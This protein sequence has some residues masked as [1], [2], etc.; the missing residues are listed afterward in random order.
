MQ[1]LPVTPSLKNP[2]STAAFWAVA[3]V[4]LFWGLGDTGLWN[5]E[6]RWVEIAREMKLSGNYF[7]P[8][9]NGAL[10]FDKPLLS[11]WLVLAFSTLTG[12][13][14]EWS[15]RLP[16]AIG[17]LL[18][19][20]ATL[21][22]GR[23][24]WS[25]SVGRL[26]GWLLLTC[27]GL[28]MWSRL[29]EADMENLAATTL[30]VYWYWRH[31]GRTGFL[32]YWIFYLIIFIGAQTKGLAAVAVPALAVLA[33]LWRSRSWRKHINFTH[34]SAMGAG[35]VFYLLPFW[36]AGSAQPSTSNGAG[37]L[38]VF[39]ENVVRYFA[40]FDHDDPFYTYFWAL[41]LL[42]MPWVPMLAG[43]FLQAWRM[44]G[45]LAEPTRWLLLAGGLIF[46]FFTVSGSRRIYYILPLLP[47]CALLTAVVYSDVIARKRLR[48]MLVLQALLLLLLVVLNLVAPL[49]GGHL[50]Q[51]LRAQLDVSS[52][53][54][55]SVIGAAAVVVWLLCAERAH[56]RGEPV[57]LLNVPALIGV[58]AMVFGGFFLVQRA[59]I[60]SYRTEWKFAEE[61]FPL[62]AQISPGQ[63]AVFRERL[64]AGVLF[65]ADL[66]VP[67]IILN[68][69]DALRNFLRTPPYPKL[70]LSSSEFSGELPAELQAAQ[71]KI[72]EARNAWEKAQV[73]KLNAW[74][75]ERPAAP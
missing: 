63:I 17:G 73:A 60:D 74:L 11:Y 43:A 7:Q 66:P 75:I 56:H 8:T 24:L 16:S 9:I 31:R 32:S 27:Y 5:S 55:C 18:T 35:L 65:Y 30:A 3:V 52:L 58:A 57:P 54:I 61:L 21:G 12:G 71:P 70:L 33:D 22:L 48:P 15:L 64:P 10:Y 38:M 42:F 69:A 62:A 53:M 68:D 67:V 26:A 1:V 45:S 46:L 28:L 14:N 41:P 59:M 13:I 36:L 2:L 23:L 20:W 37:L 25:E 50:G 6:D 47:Y 39:R 72:R 4:L 29:G 19:L 40:P 51:P 34:L 49:L 44:R